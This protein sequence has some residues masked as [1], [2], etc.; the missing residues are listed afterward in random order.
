MQADQ[1]KPMEP[2][3]D[4]RAMLRRL[5]A[6]RNERA[7]F[8]PH[9]RDLSEY[10]LPRQ[11]RFFVTDRNKGNRRTD[12]IHD[13]T[14][15]LAART[16]ASG[17]MGGLTSP[18]R[19]WFNLRTHD[20][21]LNELQ[22]VKVWLSAVRDRMNE[23]FLSSNLYTTLPMVYGDLGVFGTSAF[24]VLEDDDDVIRCVHFPIGSYM[25][26]V[27]GKGRVDTCYREFQMTVSQMVEE[28][29]RDACSQ[30]VRDM[31]DR[32]NYDAWVDIVHTV[33][34]NPNKDP[35]RLQS[36]FK[37]WRSCYFE[38]ASAGRE[39]AACLS[40]KGF[41]DFVIMAPRWQLTGEDI[42]GHSPAMDAL[43]DI[44]ALQV[45]QKR[46]MEAVAKQVNPP[47]A[48]PSSMRNAAASVL[49]GAI[50]YV[51]EGQQGDGF[52]PA[53]LVQANLQHLLEDI[54]ENQQRIKRA[55]FE[56]L[57]LMLS[58]IQHGQMTAQEV[59][60][61][62]QEK[63]LLLGPV[64][65]RLNDEL[66]GPLID[67]VFNILLK[68]NLLPPP[69]PEIHGMDLNVEYVSIMAQAAKLQSIGSVERLVQFTGSLMAADEEAKD[70]IDFDA[71]I[72]VMA[73]MLGAPPQIVRDKRSVEQ[74][75][76]G[77]RQQQRQQQ[78]MAMMQ[79]AAQTGKTLADTQVTEPSALSAMVQQM[80]GGV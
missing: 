18:S 79:Q 31:Y 74:I 80:R 48:A 25:L 22:S 9:W 46:K 23:A 60:E 55:L 62:Q 13:N 77:R 53:Y 19:P 50:T 42:Y 32:G 57:F 17:M 38:R 26:G 54:Q 49:P 28:F 29:G 52:R 47:M 30:G 41:D 65:E 2:S 33:E 36:K 16:L 14:A 73:S 7:T 75:R 76:Q 4:C 43:G 1:K 3:A 68:R 15:T 11:A 27:D 5:E 51:P 24:A 39:G 58:N 34:P 12:K 37:A 70:K 61:R 40:E 64:L 21:R 45:E 20:Q 35:R 59:A 72:D 66:F 56:D 44:K 63:L 6:L 10:V 67:R 78:A 69:P 71:T 8:V